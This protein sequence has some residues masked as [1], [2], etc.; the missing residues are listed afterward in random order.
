VSKPKAPAAPDY[1][2][3]AVAQGDA[4]KETAIANNAM[5]RLDEVTPQGTIKYT[6]REGADPNN[7][8]VGDYLRTT[9]LS[10]EQQALY[11]SSQRINQSLLN[12]GESSLAN[13]S[14]VMG[15]PLDTSGVRAYQGAPDAPQ[16]QASPG[17]V[18]YRASAAVRDGY[19]T[20]VQANG[21]AD[22]SMLGSYG[23]TGAGNYGANLPGTAGGAALGSYQ[24]GPATREL[25]DLKAGPVNDVSGAVNSLQKVNTSGYTPEKVAEQFGQVQG[26]N[27]VDD[28]SRR[29]VEEALLSRLEPQ[30]QRDEQAMRTRLLNS[31]IEVGS[32]A[33]N[34]ELD[35]LARAQ[36]DARM[37][38]VLAGGTEESRQANLNLSTQQQL[39][40][41][42]LGRGN[43]EQAGQIANNS[44]TMGAQR[45]GLESAAQN[46]AATLAGADLGLKANAQNWGQTVDVNNS[47]NKNQ[48]DEYG[49]D[50]SR[51]RL[52]NDAVTAGN[53]TAM[54]GANN[55][56]NLALQ[57]DKLRL[58]AGIAAAGLQNTAAAAR[59]A[60]AVQS[61]NWNNTALN[62]QY[63]QDA[64]GVATDNQNLGNQWLQNSAAVGVNNQNLTTN[65]NQGMAAAQMNNQLSDAEY[66]R[67]LAERNIP[68]NELNALRSGVQIANPT[69]GNYYTNGAQ[70][71]PVF[72]ATTA[73]GA[74]DMNAYNQQMAGYNGLM[75]GLAT[76]GSAFLMPTPKVR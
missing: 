50:L 49:M 75:G 44:A 29:R 39:Y 45:L 16:Y 34:D 70:A 64:A 36:N 54:S 47:V 72:D 13:V 58:D 52:E 24:K 55:A 7:P 25:T 21:F 18:D 63:A 4:N 53:N 61:G 56:A 48:L 60:A 33:Y 41:Q 67:L 5:N 28:A 40:Q 38:A 51:L 68:L 26:L 69:A 22:P 8:Q 37:Q 2:A 42:A 65:Y 9:T 20:S 23:F 14:K 59:Y 1:A 46:N 27:Q 73:Q 6:L 11:D 76:L 74:Y 66:Q 19:T 35:R 17:A 30:Y 71:A 10:P 57:A 3:A 12:T 62:D 32:Q 15:T 31:G 43:F